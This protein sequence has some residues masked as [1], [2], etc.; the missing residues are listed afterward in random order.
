[1]TK[2]P[3]RW[4]ETEGD[5]TS[6]V[7]T[8]RLVRNI[9]DEDYAPGERLPTERELAEQFDV[10]RH[11]VREA[12]KRLE[13]L[14]LVRIKQGSGAYVSDVKL[15]GGLELFEYLLFDEQGQVDL[16]ILGDF[17]VF[18]QNFA[19]EGV[20]LAAQHAT[21]EEREQLRQ[22]WHT[23]GECFDDLA[24]FAEINRALMQLVA[25][26]TH[27]RVYQLIFNNAARIFYK[28]RTGLSFAQLAPVISQTQLDRLF[29]AIEEQDPPLARLLCERLMQASRRQI[30]EQ[31]LLLANN[32]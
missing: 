21:Q 12:L 10:S 1:M 22:G 11:V 5:T 30:V 25:Q 9:L 4:L 26:A 17:F 2:S 13:V 18:W 15:T 23:R 31:F 29:E 28:I 6:R 24:G 8:T 27:N 14:G 16:S 32:T 20:A 3:F 19:C 7:L